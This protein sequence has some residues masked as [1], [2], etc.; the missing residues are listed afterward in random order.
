[1]IS[2]ILLVSH[3]KR[4]GTAVCQGL[5]NLNDRDMVFIDTA[6]ELLEQI[7]KTAPRL[8][9]MECCFGGVATDELIA[10]LI[11]KYHELNIAAWNMGPCND[12]AAARLIMA[13]A[14]SFVNLRD[15]D[16]NA[17]ALGIKTIL[18]GKPYYSAAIGDIIDQNEM[19]GFGVV[20]TRR[21]RE[22]INFIAKGKN[23]QEI[24]D[25]LG[26][27]IVTVKYHKYNVYH[28][29]GIKGD[30]QL[31][32]FGIGQGFIVPEGESLELGGRETE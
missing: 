32:L 24:A 16:G 15:A 17:M 25:C 14:A 5:F 20:F 7:K 12:A 2:R 21:E 27:S 8:V 18:A 28:K 9:L 1:M 29:T 23:N 26:I 19:P 3:A 31:C 4:L 10:S 22:I 13:G 6:E 11:R 30:G